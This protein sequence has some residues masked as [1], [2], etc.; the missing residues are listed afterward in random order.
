MLVG[1]LWYLFIKK[2]HYQITFTTPE[3]PGMVYHHLMDWPI[4]GKKDS[5]SINLVSEERYQHIAQQ[6]SVNDSLFLF[7]WSFE[8]KNDSTT[9]VKAKITDI[10]HPIKQKVQIPFSNNAF[11]KRAF[12]SVYDVAQEL[13]N[14]SENFKIGSVS[15]TLL[16][17]TYCAYIPLKA[18]T[19]TKAQVM[20]SNISFVI[21]TLKDDSISLSGPPFLEVTHWNQANDSIYFNFC[22]P[23]PKKESLPQSPYF[24]YK[25]T[26]P[27]KGLKVVFNGNYR[28][29][30][31][32]W[33]ALLDHAERNNRKVES[34]PTEV[35]WNDPHEGGESL[36]WKTDILLPLKK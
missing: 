14:K 28:I 4:Y 17:S 15:D 3:S 18:T 21:P 27:K 31:N 1:L 26:A 23:I 32:A 22:F 29:S 2:D 10:E 24:S 7:E 9:Q 33:Y 5:I 36:R 6:V 13:K 12:K 19:K 34:L 11:K 16:P 20:L 30:H 25:E 8:R 35:F